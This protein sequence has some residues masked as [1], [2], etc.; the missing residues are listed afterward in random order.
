MCNAVFDYIAV[1]L[2]ACA[3]LLFEITITKVYEYSLWGNY[4]YLVIST[5]MFGLGFSG[6]VLTRWPKLLEINE[7]RFL[8]ASAFMSALTM[9]VSFI[10]INKVPIHLPDAPHGWLNE[11]LAIALNF[12]ALALPYFFFGLMI[13]YLLEKRG[14]HAGFYYGADLIGAGVGSFIL[15]VMIPIWEPQGLAIFCVAMTVVSS[16]FYLNKLICKGIA[17]FAVFVVMG[18]LL[19]GAAVY[20]PF[21]SGNWIEIKVHVAKRNYQNEAKAG[22]IEK[23]GWSALSRVDIAP[24]INGAKRVWIAGGINESSIYEFDGDFAT[25]QGQREANI[26]RAQQVA[27]YDVMPHL[28]KTNHTVCMIGTSGGS[29]SLRSISFGARHVVG[30]EMDPMI[31]H[32]VTNDYSAY[33]GNLFNDGDYSELWVDEGRSALKRS[34]RKFDV[35]QMVNNFTPIAF[36][37]GALNLSET[38]LLTVE[39]F[40][41]FYDR[42]TDDGI[43]C[44]NRHGAVR[45]TSIAVEM[46]RRMGMT[47]EEYSKHIV[48]CRSPRH[49]A[50]TFMMKKSAF[51]P[52]EIQAIDDYFIGSPLEWGIIYAPYKTDLPES[53]S[54]IYKMLITSDHPEDYYHV[55]VF[56]F[57][58][59]TD[60]KP[61]FNHW[62]RLGFRDGSRADRMIPDEIRFIVP[63]SK[64][65]KRIDQGDLPPFIVLLE[66]IVMS[67]LF[68]GIPMLS[69]GDLR[70]KLRHNRRPLFYFACLGIAFMIIEICLMQR[71]VLFLGAPVYSIS[72]VLGSLLI[73]AGLGSMLTTRF[74]TSHK[75]VKTVLWATTVVIIVMHMLLPHIT[76]A[77]LYKTF[78]QRMII[79][80]GL[81]SVFGLFMGMPMPTGLRYLK[82]HH[83][84]II[85][86]AWAINGCFTVVGSA[87]SIILITNLGFSTVFFMAAACYAVAPVFLS[88]T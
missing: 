65:D 63:G 43:L 28:I 55:G 47:P 75:A 1:F 25:L 83:V 20:I 59:T 53:V 54:P 33:A 34:D 42:L 15:V 29:D 30:I 48:V 35:I 6:I 27:H 82:A 45:M 60:D 64:V 71:L 24:F 36:A 38:Y 56:D 37:N 16:F 5:A 78:A 46:F 26:A 77:F 85:P 10:A 58:P 72:A 51:T 66:S 32:F 23:S 40:K 70:N 4:A 84:D 73:S 17:S 2:A 86:W 57:S 41:E 81:V 67:A 19:L 12:G 61:Y 68:F 3:T 8:S 9:V 18:C 79:A 21:V 44:L 62:K 52:E 14:A 13:S 76:D 7:S 22:A 39:S 87:L 49:E 80:V 69:K 11:S 31:A 88:K 50:W 74:S